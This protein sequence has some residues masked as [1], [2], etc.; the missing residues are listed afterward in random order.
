MALPI[1]AVAAGSALSTV[2]GT[3]LRFG[4]VSWLVKFAVFALIALGGYFVGDALLPDWLSVAN[5]QN[6]VE[7]FHPAIG[8]LLNLM[9]FYSGLPLIMG[10]MVLAWVFKKIPNTVWLGPLYRL[11]N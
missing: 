7:S 11:F 9:G 2:I 3:I 8:Y 1:I 5:L 6:A 4:V 10:V